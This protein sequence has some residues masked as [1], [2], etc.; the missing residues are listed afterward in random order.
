MVPATSPTWVRNSA[1]SDDRSL[2][3]LNYSG[4]GEWLLMLPVGT[5]V[6]TLKDLI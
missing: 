4:A 6:S 5:K 2:V 1:V 3:P